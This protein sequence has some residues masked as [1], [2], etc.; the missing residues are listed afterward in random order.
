MLRRCVQALEA[1]SLPN[2][3]ASCSSAASKLGICWAEEGEPLLCEASKLL[4][5][6]ISR[7]SNSRVAQLA[8][9]RLVAYG[10][11]SL[12]RLWNVL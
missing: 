12:G 3:S 1:A 7:E 10:A 4:R 2:F 8:G 5:L 6:E 11:L 9:A